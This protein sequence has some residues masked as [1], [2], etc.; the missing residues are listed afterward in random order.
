MKKT[1]LKIPIFLGIALILFMGANRALKIFDK[2]EEK[3]VTS[4]TLM[5]AIDISELS[6]AQFTYNGIAEAFADEE[7][8]EH[9]CYIRYN[10][11][12]KA[13]IDMKKVKFEI[14]EENKTVRPILPKIKINSNP[15]G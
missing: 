7:K 11:K 13:G 12:I 1:F 5:K 15:C 6:T 3:I 2:G 10:A 14:D 9:L 4:S 8:E